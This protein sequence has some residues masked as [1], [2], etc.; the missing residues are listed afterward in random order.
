MKIIELQA[1]NI[2]K[3]VAIE[4]KP[5]G[6]LV[7]ITGRNGQGKTSILDSIWW[8]L[9]G[10]ANIQGNPI[11]KGENKA[12]IRLDLGDIVVTRTFRKSEDGHTLSSITVENAEGTA[13]RQP[14]TLLDQL[15]GELSF[16]PLAF[17]RM[18]KREQFEELKKFV[19]GVDF[20]AIEKANKADYDYRTNINRQALEAKTLAKNIF[21]ALPP[22]AQPADE[23]AL[24]N[25][26]EAAGKHNTDIAVR[27]SNREK[28]A[29]ESR[30]KNNESIRMNAEADELEKRMAELRKNA[31]TA[32]EEANS[33]S[34]KL[35]E[36]TPLP[37]PIDTVG[38]KQRIEEAKKINA[39]IRLLAKKNEYLDTTLRYEIESDEVTARMNARDKEKREKIAAAKLPVGEISFGD[40]EIL[41]NDI[42]FNQA[43]DSEQLQVSIAIAMALNPKLRIIRVRD[44][45]LLDEDSLKLLSGMAD[46]EDFQV[47]IERVDSSGKVGFVIED[48][49]IKQEVAKK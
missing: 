20:D 46:S 31:V 35:S 23:I 4:I 40:N 14:Q 22:D 18:P 48:G 42:P 41:L 9:S 30:N 15:I 6:N 49:H 27:K 43:S 28:L 17:A 26:L 11:R 7:Q 21:V 36:A 19:P 12:R 44:G 5:D 33:I 34:K 10:A 13:I 45:S 3:L 25:E 24:L 2:K 39:Q 38:I 8:A 37:D 1:E 47:W 29:T 16:D 32:Q